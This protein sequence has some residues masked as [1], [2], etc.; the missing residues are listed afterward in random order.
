MMLH[1][2]DGNGVIT[3]VSD[4]WLA[5]LG[6][7]WDE[8]IGR[9]SVEFLTDESARYAREVVLPAFFAQGTCDVEYDMRRKDGSV[10][11]VRLTGDAVRN[12]R[13]AFVR[14][15]AVIED[16]SER[17]ALEKKMF[18][19]QQ[20]ES[21]GLMA[22]NIAH[23]FNNLLTSVIGNAQLAARH[24][25]QLPAA[26]SALD[27]VL[28]AAAR[29]A[30]LCQQLLAYSGRGRFE[31]RAIDVDALI[32]EMAQVLEVPVGQRAR[33][34]L[35]PARDGAHVEGD[36]TQL[37]QIV[38]NLVLNAADA[39]DGVG[40]AITIRTET[41]DL[42]ADAIAASARPEVPP[43]RYASVA[44]VDNGCGMT[45]AT[46]ARM[47][48]PFFS[49]KATGRGLGL[50]A[51]LGIVRGHR[52]TLTVASE[53]GHGTRVIVFLPIASPLAAA[54]R[55]ARSTVRG[56]VLVV[57][58]NELLRGT[59]ARQLAEAGFQAIT[60]GSGREAIALL[61]DPAISTCVVDISMPD[62]TGPQLAEHITTVA[63]RAKIVLMSGYDAVDVRLGPDTQFLRKP[64]TEREL[65]AAID[66]G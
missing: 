32:V 8:V 17:R 37:R 56:K 51:I 44:V 38:M 3:E 10:L 63:P 48:D 28:L 1:S 5:R 30:D 27:N 31:V 46:R 9:R 42:D 12:E 65:L 36:A 49:T 2:I 55:P 47:F 29:A 58:D 41:V 53:L 60:A 39:I 43:G 24:A 59:I 66:R 33:I 7:T 25:R 11:P 20:L 57:D 21:L 35:E 34:V 16:L 26:A 61:A 62:M 40:G 4:M 6:Y 15:I 23:D 19:V 54:D 45:A 13:G 22:G 14:S 64:F 50:A 52:G 18:E